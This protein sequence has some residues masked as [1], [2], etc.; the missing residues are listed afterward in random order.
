MLGILPR[1]SRHF[2]L[3]PKSTIAKIYAVFTFE[4]EDLYEEFHLILMKNVSGYPSSCVERKHD[5][6]GS[7]VD[8]A[9]LDESNMDLAGGLKFAGIMKDK[10]FD[11]YEERLHIEESFQYDLLDTLVRDAAFFRMEGLI[12]YSLVVYLVDKNKVAM[13]EDV[14]K[15]SLEE[16]NNMTA[17]SLLTQ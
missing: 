7:T 15:V 10:D 11:K 3:N 8:R 17:G 16:E 2:E 5:L 6:K 14:R 12:D 1:Y 9:V 4:I 13:G